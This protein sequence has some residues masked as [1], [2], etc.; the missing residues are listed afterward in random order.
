MKDVEKIQKELEKAMM[1][2]ATEYTGKQDFSVLQ[3]LITKMEE[4]RSKYSSVSNMLKDYISKSEDFDTKLKDLQSNYIQ[5]ENLFTAA[6]SKEY[7]AREHFHDIC[8]KL[9]PFEFDLIL[10]DL[11]LEKEKDYEVSPSEIS[12]I[13]LLKHIKESD[14]SVPVIVLTAS[15]KALNYRE[16]INLGAS[17][18]WIKA[19]KSASDLKSEIIKALD[20]DKNIRN[21]WLEI[22]KVEAKKQLI[23]F[24]ETSPQYLEKGVMNPVQKSNIISLL[25]ESFLLLQR[26]LSTYEKS[27]CNYTNY[28]KIVLNMGLIQ[29]VR[30]HNIKAE[31]YHYWVTRGKIPPGEENIRKLR[32]RVAHEAGSKVSYEEVV[33][34]FKETLERCLM[35]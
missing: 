23:Y 18:Y 8:M 25:K 27:I 28:E 6:Q 1:D 30:L 20:M 31:R 15:E 12:G 35:Y 17:G 29:E 22:K 26:E 19:V 4:L 10:L 5:V 9:V 33:N 7:H 34:V 11:R 16:A 2:F 14:P 3:S 21:L 32:H 24:Y 13:K